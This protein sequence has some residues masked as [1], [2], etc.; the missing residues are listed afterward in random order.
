[1]SAP[2]ASASGNAF[3]LVLLK[4]GGTAAISFDVIDPGETAAYDAA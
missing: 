4:T 1:M 3:L 2:A